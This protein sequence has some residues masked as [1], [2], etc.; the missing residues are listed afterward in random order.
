VKYAAEKAEISKYEL[1]V[2]PEPK[3]LLDIL[4]KGLM[5]KDEDDD[6]VQTH[7]GFN[8]LLSAPVLQ[9]ALPLIEQLDPVKAASIKRG[10]MQLDLLGTE[11][12]L[13]ADPA[14]PMIR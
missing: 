13:L 5:G 8:K 11:K 1:R 7:I 10:L 14:I 9:Q 4:M 3:T 2:L 12:V 6:A